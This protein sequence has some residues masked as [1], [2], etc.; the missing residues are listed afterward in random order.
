MVAQGVPCLGP[1][2]HA[3]CGAICPGYDRGCY[4]CYGPAKTP[5]VASLARSACRATGVL[6][7]PS[8]A[9]CTP[10]M[11]GRRSSGKRAERSASSRTSIQEQTLMSRRPRRPSRTIRVQA[12]AR[13]EGE[14][15]LTIR[16]RDGQVEA[17]RAAHFEPPRFFEALLR[18]RAAT[19][20]PDIT[21]RICGICPV[22]YQ[23]SSVHAME[24]ISGVTMP[25]AI[26]GAS[27]AALLRR[28]DRKPR[29]AHLFAARPG[30][31]RLRKRHRH[32]PGR[33]RSWPRSSAAACASRRPATPSCGS[34]AAGRSTRS[35]SRSG[36][37]YRVPRRDELDAAARRFEMRPAT[38]R[39]K[40]SAGRRRLP[41]PDFEDD[42]EFVALRHPDEYPMNEGRLVSS[43]GPDI[44]AD[45]I[46]RP[47]RGIPGAAFQRPAIAAARRRRRLLRRSAGAL[48]PERRPGQSAGPRGGGGNRHRA[49]RTAI[50]M[51]ASSPAAWK[52][53]WPSMRRCGSSRITTRRRCRPWNVAAAGRHRP[54]DHRGAARHPLSS[55]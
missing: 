4:G 15:G 30:L 17:R 33:P 41:F 39:R 7:E 10:S 54:R 48:E 40:R 45:G 28:M 44:A 19:E 24:K 31:P 49:S 29:A 47:F 53:C 8:T 3:G 51:S 32:G 16:L 37:F 12:L 13:V 43:R 23:M 18:G 5:N 14:G 46:P 9:C 1:V 20:V 11:P 52:C 34:S 21:A 36:G 55:L 26:A 38:Q 6:P 50:R 42:Y 27:P 2:T 35:T 25:P 22:A